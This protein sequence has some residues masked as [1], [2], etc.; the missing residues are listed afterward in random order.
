MTDTGI[1]KPSTNMKIHQL[2]EYFNAKIKH[3]ESFR[4]AAQSS[5]LQIEQCL[6]LDLLQLNAN[7]LKIQAIQNNNEH[8]S[9]LLLGYECVIGSVRAEL[10]MW[11]L[12]KRDMP[13]QAWEQLISAQIACVDASRADKGFSHCQ[14]RLEDLNRYEE[15]LFP[16]QAFLSAGFISDRLDCSICGNHYAKCKHLHGAPYMGQFCTI[17]HR[18][19]RGNHIA[20][21]DVPADKRCRVTAFQVKEGYQ[22]KLSGEITPYEEDE[23]FDDSGGLRMRTIMM[24]LD[25]YPYLTLAKDILAKSIASD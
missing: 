21:V 16:P 2:I 25:R 14:L 10:L 22:D 17:I 9:N 7:R 6:A 8:D 18:N 23:A 15:L 19:P 12:L 5:R 20:L 4:S 3:A 13:N 1:D 11:I 24:A